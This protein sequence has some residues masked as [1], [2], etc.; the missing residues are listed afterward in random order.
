MLGTSLVHVSICCNFQSFLVCFSSSRTFHFILAY[1]QYVLEYDAAVRHICYY[2]SGLLVV[3]IFKESLIL[4]FWIL[5]Y[6]DHTAA[7]H[8]PVQAV[9]VIISHAGRAFLYVASLNSK[10]CSWL[11]YPWLFI[12][13]SKET[14]AD[15]E[16]FMKQYAISLLF[17]NLPNC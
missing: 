9:K 6:E 16:P 8:M 2:F 14:F 3:H 12:H 7:I 17:L 4:Y 11:L 10:Q 15:F 5:L 13:Y 1:S